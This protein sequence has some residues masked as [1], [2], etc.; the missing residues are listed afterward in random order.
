MPIS[1]V[2]NEDNMIGMARYPDKFF[3][4]CICDPPY[5][6]DATNMQMGTNISRARKHG[7]VPGISTASRLKRILNAEQISWDLKPPGPEYFKELFR[8]SKHQIIWGG[9][10]FNLPPTRGIICWDKKQEWTSFSQWEMAWT[11]FDVPARI[12][13]YSNTGGANNEKKI[14][15]T[16]KPVALYKWVL[17]HYAQPGNKILDTHMGSQSSRIAAYQMGFDYFGWETDLD[18]F[19]SGN[20]RFTEQTAQLKLL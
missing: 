14:H 6:I 20:R 12:F 15:Q 9:N 2:Y 1:E 7:K 16:Q 11:S 5:G 18:Y 13:R 10:Y 19:W 3:E 4:L 17:Q 8:V